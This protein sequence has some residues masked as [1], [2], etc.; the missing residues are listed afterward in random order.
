MH[1]HFKKLL[2]IPSLLQSALVGHQAFVESPGHVSNEK[3]LR[4]SIKHGAD[5]RRNGLFFV[6]FLFVLFLA[7]TGQV[8]AVVNAEQIGYV[9]CSMTV[10]AVEG[11]LELGGG[12]LWPSAEENYSS[13][14]VTYWAE[15]LSGINH[16]WDWLQEALIDQPDTTVIWWQLCALSKQDGNDRTL[17]EDAR[18]VRD[19]IK[20]LAPEATIYVSAQPSYSDPNSPVDPVCRIAGANGPQR[21]EELAAELVSEGGVEQGPVLGPLTPDLLLDD[22]CHANSEGELFMGQQLADFFGMGEGNSEDSDGDSVNDNLD[23]CPTVSNPDQAD[24]DDDGVGDACE[25]G[26]SAPLT[27]SPNQIGRGTQTTLALTGQ[28]FD[29]GMT[30]SIVPFPAGVRIESV[31]VKSSTSATIGVNVASTARQGGR[32]IKVITSAG[33][34]ATS[35]FAFKV[36]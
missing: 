3:R 4:K 22:G 1:V 5:P 9:G 36:Q 18:A 28:G 12:S 30:V 32:G 11:Y 25:S 10:D 33:Q 6:P 23:N 35:Q 14:G 15:N 13:G 27:V 21:M 29:S 20:R 17:L 19:E 7:G 8:K 2:S 34:T 24:T 26:S 31:T 16:Y